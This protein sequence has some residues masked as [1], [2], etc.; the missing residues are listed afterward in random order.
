MHIRVKKYCGFSDVVVN[1][2]PNSQFVGKQAFNVIN[3]AFQNE[4][5]WFVA[6]PAVEKDN[7]GKLT[8][9]KL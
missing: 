2:S 5:I 1:I 9:N 7:D 3:S 4:N 6:F 8:S